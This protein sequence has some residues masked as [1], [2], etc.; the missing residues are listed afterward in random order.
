MKFSATV[1]LALAAPALGQQPSSQQ[2]EAHPT[3]NY[4]DCSA[5]G[6]C[7]KTASTFVLDS[8]WRWSDVDAVNC[9]EGNLWNAEL[10]PDAE[11]CAKACSV[12]GAA[13]ADTY[14]I[15]PSDD[16]ES[17]G[18]RMVTNGTYSR[19]V[20]SRVY[21]MD[22]DDKAYKQFMLKNKEF[23][24][25]VD[26]SALG[27]GTNAALYFVEMDKDGNMGD[28]DNAVGAEYG[29]GYCD[30]QC[31]HDLKWINGEANLVDWIPDS[32]NPDTGKGKYGT[33]CFELDI[34][35]ANV[36]SQQTTPHT[37]TVEGQYRCESA[38]DCGDN[39]GIHRDTGVCDKN[40]CDF[41]PS[42]L[43][44]KD[45]YGNGSDFSV[46]SSKP[47]T[48][49]TQF[50]TAD[51]TDDGD[52]SEIRRYYV[53]DGQ[54]IDNV[55]VSFDGSDAT[56]DSITDDFCDA[57][58]DAFATAGDISSF[59]DRGGMKAM[60]E[61]MSRGL[62]LVLSLWDDY[63]V[64]ML[65][66]DSLYPANK[67]MADVPGV[68]RGPCDI[69]SGDPTSV[70]VEYADA[71]VYWSAIKTGPIGFTEAAGFGSDDSAPVVT[72]DSSADCSKQYNQCGGDN[73]EGAT[74]CEEG[75][76]C[77]VQNEHYSQCL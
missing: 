36:E 60:G 43:G 49:V 3:L 17:V 52:L 39:D 1:A 67:S 57:K 59:Q 25:T 53:Q 77:Q 14:G 29:T 27:C 33:C 74:C 46:D 23:V 34:W 54:K 70:E 21:M 38:E 44:Y 47:I 72:D 12:E 64:N 32:N 4:Y 56:Y 16:G 7:E 42:R 26:L 2:D 30:A 31:P 6:E 55:K 76:T 65:W 50:I 35:E 66:L 15:T 58:T 63:S 61:S 40:G 37:C 20:G 69:T 75:S 28:G 8:N 45:F 18:L 5:T 48:V 41:N 9:Y 71:T 11:T 22:D 68:Y 51:G 19:S 73:W 10:C 24:F 13:Y 62:T